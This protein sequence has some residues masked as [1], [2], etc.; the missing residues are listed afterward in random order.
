MPMHAFWK[1]VEAYFEVPTT[2]D[3]AFLQHLCSEVSTEL[4]QIQRQYVDATC[5]CPTLC[6][7]SVIRL[8]RLQRAS[9]RLAALARRI[10]PLGRH[11]TEAWQEEDFVEE[12]LGADPVRRCGPGTARACASPVTSATYVL[13]PASRPFPSQSGRASARSSSAR[14]FRTQPVAALVQ[15]KVSARLVG[16]LLEDRSGRRNTKAAHTVRDAGKQ[17]RKARA[18]WHLRAPVARSHCSPS[19]RS[20]TRPVV[21]SACARRRAPSSTCGRAPPRPRSAGGARLWKRRCC[22]SSMRWAC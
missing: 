3:Q 11:Y 4:K 12:Q 20:L 6:R 10:P 16:S 14:S 5:R 19:C 18:R 7:T 9:T 1:D 17:G 22:T 8:Q 2:A 13:H 21:R 15:G